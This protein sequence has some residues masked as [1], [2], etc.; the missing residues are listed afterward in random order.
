[1][2]NS[3][4]TTES[5]ARFF[6]GSGRDLGW[7]TTVSKRSPLLGNL[8]V[9]DVTTADASLTASLVL[10]DRKR[11]SVRS[12]DSSEMSYSFSW[13]SGYTNGL[14]IRIQGVLAHK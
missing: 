2:Q 11:L 7:A 4:D 13:A 12:G 10:L 3:F 5:G 9:L 6:D 1:M 8:T 14:Q